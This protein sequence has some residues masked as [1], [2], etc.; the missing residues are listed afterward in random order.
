MPRLIWVFAWRT[1]HFVGFVMRRLVS[2]SCHY[3]QS[4][5]VCLGSIL[6]YWKADW[7]LAI[8][9]H[10]YMMLENTKLFHLS[11][12]QLYCAFTSQMI[13]M[14]LLTD[15]LWIVHYAIRVVEFLHLLYLLFCVNKSFLICLCF[16][17]KSFRSF[18]CVRIGFDMTP[19]PYT[20]CTYDPRYSHVRSR[21]NFH[22]SFEPLRSGYR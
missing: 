13:T 17:S 4:S 9:C 6:Q 16:H 19:S 7:T 14:H 12:Q 22:R 3:L 8:C 21:I 15:V 5:L 11:G 1:C 20:F 10:I 18:K 2:I